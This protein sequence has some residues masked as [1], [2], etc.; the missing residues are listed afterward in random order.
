MHITMVCSERR[1]GNSVGAAETY[2]VRSS[3]LGDVGG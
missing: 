1:N 2:N 3:N